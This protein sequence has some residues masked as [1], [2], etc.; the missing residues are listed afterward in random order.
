VTPQPIRVT[1]LPVYRCLPV[2]IALAA[3]IAA[4]PARAQFAPA[5]PGLDHP[6]PT[7]Q[8]DR[9]GS[10]NGPRIEVDGTAG[11]YLQ[12]LEPKR[13][14][15][16]V[17]LF[18]PAVVPA[19]KFTDRYNTWKLPQYLSDKGYSVVLLDPG[20]RNLKWDQNLGALLGSAITQIDRSAQQFG[21][22][23]SKLIIVAECDALRAGAR[24][25][26]DPRFTGAQHFPRIRAILL[27]EGSCGASA[28]TPVQ[29]LPAVAPVNAPSFFV[30]TVRGGTGTQGG[31]YEEL[32]TT[33]TRV[34][35]LLVARTIWHSDV[36]RL[37]GWLNPDADRLHEF[38]GELQ[39]TPTR[40]R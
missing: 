13:G 35:R 15:R 26:L 36:S 18:L 8:K 19:R 24:A 27:I 5:E 17:V 22:D 38:L 6:E 39:L 21:F 31:I 34:E 11:A 1:A 29:P 2:A 4:G 12:V 25:G 14:A 16:P 37:G 30:I 3:L 32:R 28:R 33:G 20:A 9:A 23:P 40:G 7:N 10:F